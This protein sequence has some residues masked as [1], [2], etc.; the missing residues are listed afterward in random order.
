MIA[1]TIID[2]I[3]TLTTRNKKWALTRFSSSDI[4][5]H[6]APALDAVAATVSPGCLIF[7]RFSCCQ[8]KNAVWFRLGAFG[9][10]S[11]FVFSFLPS[12][13]FATDLFFFP[14]VLLFSFFSSAFLAF[15]GGE[16]L[17]RSSETPLPEP[18]LSYSSSGSLPEP[19]DE[20]FWAR[21][22]FKSFSTS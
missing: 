11:F 7:D 2:Q 16:W 18:S 20:L 12:L 8:M 6:I 21:F 13:V 3:C 14:S 4:D 17:M 10:F 22:L 15:F 1:A 19:S 9:S 5:F